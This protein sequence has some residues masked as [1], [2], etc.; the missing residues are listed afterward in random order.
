M[1]TLQL[2]A[3]IF[4]ITAFGGYVNKKYFGFPTTIGVLL[5]S[6]FLSFLL[7]ILGY[8]NLFNLP[9]LA[10]ALKKLD[11]SDLLLD[12]ILCILLF[13]GALNINFKTLKYYFG[14]IFLY[15]TL[16]VLLSS[17]LTAIFLYWFITLGLKINI[18]FMVCF[19]F[20][21]LIS[22]TDPV[23]ILSILNKYY[24]PS[25]LK[26]KISG[27]SLFNDA[28]AIV[29]FLSISAVIFS[30]KYSQ[31][32]IWIISWAFIF[33]FVGAIFVGAITSCIVWA[34]LKNIDS[35]EIEIMLTIALAIGSYALAQAIHVCAPLACVISGLFI[36][37]HARKSLMSEETRHR[38]DI[39]W[40]LLD[41]I[42]NAALFVVIGLE[43]ILISCTALIAY[44][45]LFAL[46]S[47]FFARYLSILA[48]NI[49]SFPAYFKT[50]TFTNEIIKHP[51]LMAWGG[52]RGGISIAL[53]LSMPNSFEYKE[54]FLTATFIV[55]I[56][57][58]AIQGT[59][60]TKLIKLLK[61]PSLQAFK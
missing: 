8:L 5:F 46:I 36:G 17:L 18:D 29:L 30:D 3:L 26:A 28:S 39:F 12:G 49:I 35:Y 10:H 2:I 45:G 41:E 61:I 31:P 16:G 55:V 24:S 37:N 51:I 44:G 48:V 19:L 14:A 23:A 58:I 32:D 13:A 11:F 42:F 33:K 20:G 15:S 6:V 57:S 47:S 27:E 4:S 59:T 60:F 25:D 43:L 21:A 40:K 34:L 56:F 50:S 22:P 38:V 1:Q 54:L 52:L 9:V 53:A 7:M